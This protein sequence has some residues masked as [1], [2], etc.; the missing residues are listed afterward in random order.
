MFTRELPKMTVGELG[1][2]LRVQSPETT[3]INRTS[4]VEVDLVDERVIRLTDHVE[5]PLRAEVGVKSLAKWLDI[6]YKFLDRQTRDLQ[7]Y[8]ISTLLSRK[9][10]EA[11]FA[12]STDYGL[13]GVS[14]P[15]VEV[16]DP[17]EYAEIVGRVI[18]PTAQVVDLFVD[19]DMVQ[20][21][22]TV[23]EGYDFGWGGDPQVDDITAGGLRVGQNRKQNL[24]PW[25]Q[26]FTYRLAC[27]NGM[28]IHEPGLKVD[29]RGN[30]IDD[31]LV[32]L[33]AKARKAFGRIEDKIA[34]FYELREQQV[35]DPSQALLRIGEEAG[36]PNRTVMT[37][38]EGVPELRGG[39]DVT[40]FGLVNLIT[41]MANDPSIE[42]RP[43][44]R[45]RLEQAGGMQVAD[46]IARCPSCQHRLHDN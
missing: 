36:L 42:G 28:E 6:P 2:H 9:E 45:R 12:Y 32:E 5:V 19:E 34:S 35:E 43:H 44:I 14:K 13:V 15:N 23:P 24:A 21:S 41:N 3:V 33:E 27:T 46:H 16:I 31:V 38:L 8:L 18:D 39:G 20:F 30:T 22:A 4:A 10:D 26:P 29:A 17:R 7:Q 37:L 11:R 25:V 40:Q 1:D